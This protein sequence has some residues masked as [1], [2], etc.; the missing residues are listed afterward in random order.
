MCCACED[1]LFVCRLRKVK[2]SKYVTLIKNM[3]C[4][5]PFFSGSSEYF[6]C[7]RWYSVMHVSLARQ[8]STSNK[9][10]TQSHASAPMSY[11]H[12]ICVY[13]VVS[14]F[15]LCSYFTL[16]T[17]S[18]NNMNGNGRVCIIWSSF[19]LPI[20]PFALQMCFSLFFFFA[21]FHTITQRFLPY[22]LLYYYIA[23]YTQ[24]ASILSFK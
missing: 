5:I 20:L 6:A 18:M 7:G 1:K 24:V 15:L 14:F 10:L 19:I 2:T 22:C 13:F 3:V 16:V 9:L 8:K 11:S 4:G 21:Y 23:I 17:H 12:G